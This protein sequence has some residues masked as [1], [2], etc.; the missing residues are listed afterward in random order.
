MKTIIPANRILSAVTACIP[1]IAKPMFSF[2]RIALLIVLFF[3]FGYNAVLAQ[4]PLCASSPTNFGFEYVSSI[5]ING[6][7][8]AGNTGY[9]GPGYYDYTGTSLTNFVA[10]NTYAVSVVVQTK[11][12]YQEYVKLWFDFNGNQNLE[13]AGELVFDQNATFF[14][15]HTYSGNITVPANTYNG[16]VYLRAIMVFSAT[17]QLCGNYSFGNT[18]DFKATISGGL[19]SRTLT[20]AT[21]GSAGSVASSPTGINTASGINSSNFSDGSVVNLTATPSGSSA[22]VNWSGSATGSSNPLAVTMSAAKSITANFALPLALTTTAVSSIDAA[23]ASS[24]GNVTGDG[25]TAVTARGVCW[26]TTGTPTTANTKTNDGTGTGAFSSSLTGLSAN[27]TYYVRAYATNASTTAYGS[28]VSF[29][30]LPAAPTS[31][32]AVSSTLCNG[33]STT[34][35]ANGAQGTVYWYTGSCGGTL[36]GTG[37]SISVSPAT[38]TTYFARNNNGSFSNSCASTTITVNALPTATISPSGSNAICQGSSIT[39]TA[40]AGTGYQWYKD[41][42]TIS[43]A[44]SQTYNATAAGTYTVAVSNSAGCSATSTGTTVTVNALPTI[45]GITG[46]LSV[47]SGNTTTLTAAS[48]ATSPVFKW[49]NTL[50][51]GTAIYTG[52]SYTTDVLTATGTYYVDVTNGS[53]CTASARTTV[54]VTVNPLPTATIYASGPT[55]FCAGNSVTLNVSALGNAMQLSG[56]QYAQSNNPA[57]PVGNASRTIEAWVKTSTSTNGVVANWG[58]TLTNQRSGLIVVNNHLYYVGENNDLQGSINISTNSWH[59]VAITFDGTTLKLY[60]DGVLDNSSTKTFNTTGTTLRIGQRSVGD[61]GSELYNGIID[62]LRIWNVARTQAELQNN[63]FAE[64]PGN[65]A[66]LV[67]YYKLN[68]ATGLSLTDASVKQCNINT[69]CSSK[70]D[71][72]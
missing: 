20:V 64:I 49:Y 48:L 23:T 25:G 41:G 54:T 55:T 58:N 16:T 62:E 21:A 4:S 52:A 24:G 51:G 38:T 8:K 53:S 28:Q 39:L 68:E 40:A 34:L 50:T 3:T 35:T 71:P 12:S 66:G 59:H 11:G 13:D 5:T 47:C 63:R 29:L 10:G 17:P 14:G 43:L 30:T 60:V 9:T 27:T 6:V 36:I 56:T 22:F 72:I 19:V 57:L 26:N 67:A 18:F 61:A 65:S 32:S 44:N 7:T 1:G 37:N 70:L 46:T 31:I 2:K 15:T 42:N 45:S 69:Y 33:Q